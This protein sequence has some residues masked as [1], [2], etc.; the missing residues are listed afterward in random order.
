MMM[1]KALLGGT[2][3]YET[4]LEL[5]NTSRQDTRVSPAEMMFRRNTRSMLPSVGTKRIRCKRQVT[6]RRLKRRLSIKRNYDKGARDLKRL[7][8]GQPVYYQHT[9][10]KKC[11]CRR[12][13]VRT[14][15]SDRSYIIDGKEVIYKRNRVHLRPTTLSASPERT[16]QPADEN[17]HSPPA[18][19]A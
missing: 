16:P 17:A 15:H 18:H 12:G 1:R 19:I 7:A 5:R 13:T 3:Q 2:D 11:D 8:P 10:G 4:L 6:L 9:E 14:E